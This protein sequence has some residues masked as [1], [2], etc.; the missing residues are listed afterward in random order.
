MNYIRRFILAVIIMLLLTCAWY[1]AEMLIHGESQRSAV[2][3]IIAVM[4]SLAISGSIERSVE[5]SERKQELAREFAK[6]FIKFT[7]ERKKENE[8]TQDS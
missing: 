1:G 8:R 7:E 6:D 3:L 2:D 5:Y 4:I